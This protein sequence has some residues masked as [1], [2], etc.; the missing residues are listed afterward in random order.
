TVTSETI[1]D[2]AVEVNATEKERSPV[3]AKSGNNL[4]DYSDSSESTKSLSDGKRVSGPEVVVMGNSVTGV[5]HITKVSDT[6]IA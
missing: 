4:V 2:N 6:G 1:H 3:V 5:E